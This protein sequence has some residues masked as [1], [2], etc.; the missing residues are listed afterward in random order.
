[1]HYAPYKT[2][3]SPKNNMNLYRGCTYGCIYCDSRSDCYQLNHV[4]EDIEVK[5][6]A[7]AIL[8]D[9][10]KRK[11]KPAMVTTG[12]MTDPYLHTE[13]RLQLT[14]QALALI[15]KY[16]F[17]IAIQTK[18]SRILRDLDLLQ[19]I[20][21]Q[22]KAVVQMTLTTYDEKLCKLIE[23]NVATTLERFETLKVFQKAGIPTVVWL[24]PILPFINDTEENLLGILDYCIQAGVKGI[25]CFSFG[26]T[27]RAGNR[28]YFYRKLDQ[29][30]P[31]VKEKYIRA[32]GNQYVCNSLNHSK[33]MA[34]FIKTCQANHIMYRTE[35]IFRFLH[36][37]EGQ[38]EQLSL[39]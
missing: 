36:T 33:L 2:I 35:E 19:E 37:Y 17:G 20:H 10:L 21:H 31:G 39:F 18:S 12:A 25:L 16:R 14:R 30:F 22:T 1:M 15:K 28:D 6:N 38:E 29:H 7:V 34:L 3:L 32:Y 5:E 8:E 23:P 11:R 27:L 24:S 4:F 9:Q 26:V 13:E